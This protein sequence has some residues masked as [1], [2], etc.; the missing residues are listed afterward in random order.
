MFLHQQPFSVTGNPLGVL[1]PLLM[2]DACVLCAVCPV[3]WKKT[4][5]ATFETWPI[6]IGLTAAKSHIILVAFTW[7]GVPFFTTKLCHFIELNNVNGCIYLKSG[8]LDIHPSK[9]ASP[10][11]ILL[12]FFFPELLYICRVASSSPPTWAEPHQSTIVC[13]VEVCPRDNKRP[14]RGVI[15]SQYAPLTALSQSKADVT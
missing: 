3:F 6:I 1:W 5:A 12:L 15:R 9:V 8:C 13:D 4:Q 14:T 7:C 11:K 2:S 10:E